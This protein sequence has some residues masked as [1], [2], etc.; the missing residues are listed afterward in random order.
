MGHAGDTY[1][2]LPRDLGYAQPKEYL[3]EQSLGMGYL[4][5][6]SRAVITIR[7]HNVYDRAFP[8]VATPCANLGDALRYAEEHF[9][10]GLFGSE[11]RKTELRRECLIGIRLIGSRIKESRW[12]DCNLF[13]AQLVGTDIS[14]SDFTECLFQEAGLR[15]LRAEK[16]ILADCCFVKA[17]L[18]EARMRGAYLFRASFKEANLTSANLSTAVATNADFTGANLDLSN[19]QRASL[20][21]SNLTRV[22]NFKTS[23]IHLA[24]HLDQVDMS[25]DLKA[26]LDSSEWQEKRDDEVV[27]EPEQAQ[28]GAPMWTRL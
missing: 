24:L 15:D 11:L 23:N 27:R 5:Q 13:Q 1:A 12:V 14:E 3:G 22:T 6:E 28:P 20:A 18:Q 17:D 7:K 10:Y 8:E 19:F 26:Y 4:V 9:P 21:G 16:S 2:R 25:D